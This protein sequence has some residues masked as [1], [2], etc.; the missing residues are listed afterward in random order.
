MNCW[1]EKAVKLAYFPGLL[2]HEGFLTGFLSDPMIFVLS[3]VLLL[4][5]LLG[6]ARIK[7]FVIW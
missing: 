7:S 3:E 4:E 1:N 6:Q 2:V 5:K